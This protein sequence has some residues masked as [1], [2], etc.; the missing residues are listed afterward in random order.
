MTVTTVEK[1]LIGTRN[2]KL[3]RKL[4]KKHW[5]QRFMSGFRG[6]CQDSEVYVGMQENML[7]FLLYLP[8]ILFSFPRRSLQSGHIKIY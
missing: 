3:H 6:L 2:E 7:L 8:L 5:M 1:A 4:D